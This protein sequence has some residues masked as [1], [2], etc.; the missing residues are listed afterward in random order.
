MKE[1]IRKNIYWF[2]CSAACAVILIGRAVSF[3]PY[4][5]ATLNFNDFPVLIYT[6][7]AAR[8][9]HAANGLLWGYDPHFMAG[10]PLG[11]IWNSNVAIQWLAVHFPKAP[12]LTVVRWFFQIG[13]LSFPVFWWLTLRNFGLTRRESA[14]GFLLG[15]FYFLLGMP[16]LFFAAGMLTAGAITYFSLFA[17]SCVYRYSRDGGAW[18]FA[19]VVSLA[20]GLF[21]HK[22]AALILLIPGFV[23]AFG[24]V[25][26]KH[27]LRFAGLVAA[28]AVAVAVN[29]FWIKPVLLFANHIKNLSEAP[30][31]QNKDLLRPLKDY[32]TGSVVMNNLTF[33]GAYGAI[34]SG[35][36]L[37]LLAT[38]VASLYRAATRGE[39]EKA[40]F[41]GASAA[42]LWLYSYYGA[43]LPIGDTLNPTRYFPVA[44]LLLA[45]AGG[46]A[47]VT[48]NG[49]ET[50][51]KSGWG[52]G[53]IVF[54]VIPIICLAGMIYAA[55]R[56]RP[57]EYLLNF[58]ANRDVADLTERIKA[59]PGGARIM[60]EDSGVM[61]A[62]SGGQVYGNSQALS[63]FGLMTGKE[64]VG[65]PYPYVFED[66]HYVSF[67]DGRAFGKPLSE[68]NPEE[69][70]HRLKLYN[71]KWIV[72]W[73]DASTV[74]F[75]KYAGYFK[76]FHR[77]GKFEF[78]EVLPYMPTYFLK[79]SGEVGAEYSR[80]HVHQR[81]VPATR[82]EIVLAQN[83]TNTPESYNVVQK[84]SEII[85]KYHW[86]PGLRVRPPAK[87]EMYRV[88]GDPVGFIK[89]VDP[90]ENFDIYLQ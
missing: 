54:A 17:A 46:A 8:R 87:L 66:Y 5:G 28:V 64:F 23:A 22:T 79:G 58:P 25:K 29:W 38:G 52:V 2:I 81:Y 10:Y 69:L 18:W 12:V 31:W 84:P 7:E 68:F 33:S 36:L 71:V 37:L 49:S 63:N 55:N 27:F 62:E 19:V 77:V 65:G 60:I 70:L 86:S 41:I 57:F 34:H 72:C 80:I 78:F 3:I 74:Y 39:K 61:D 51:E 35:L 9:F 44:Q 73:S 48:K 13:L 75:G 1:T 47:V 40:L 43:Y 15:G 11:F 59:L 32:F 76:S 53:K 83:N 88:E 82:G 85:L 30:F 24:M 26:G 89:V 21:I 90:P 14:V 6:A 20:V 4:G 50:G 56:L 45:A 67:Q 16:V 42:G